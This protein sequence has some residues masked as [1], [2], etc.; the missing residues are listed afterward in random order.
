[1]DKQPQPEAVIVDAS[2]H[3]LSIQSFYPD[4]KSQLS[5]LAKIDGQI[6][7]ITRM[8]EQRRYCIDIVSQIKAVQSALKQVQMGVLETHIHHCVADAAKSDDAAAINDKIEEI[9]R[10]VSRLD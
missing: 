3:A 4:H 6:K 1:M 8:I 7:G 10:V 9:V 2:H 5:R